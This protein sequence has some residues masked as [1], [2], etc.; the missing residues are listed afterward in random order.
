MTKWPVQKQPH[1]TPSIQ[2]YLFACV[3]RIFLFLFFIY[4]FLN[5]FVKTYCV[6]ALLRSMTFIGGLNQFQAIA[7]L[8]LFQLLLKKGKMC[9]Y[10]FM[11]RKE[12]EKRYI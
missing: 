10:S 2:Y 1:R 7:N 11:N 6:S 12:S 8:T 3:F 9:I 4:D 5:D